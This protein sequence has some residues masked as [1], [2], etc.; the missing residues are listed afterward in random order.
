MNNR[1]L[2]KFNKLHIVSILLFAV[3]ILQSVTFANTKYSFRT[4]GVTTSDD[5][6]EGS[7]SDGETA[8]FKVSDNDNGIISFSV[9]GD[10]SIASKKWGLFTVQVLAKMADGTT[11]EVKYTLYDYN[12]GPGAVVPLASVK[13]NNGGYVINQ[14]T[15]S[16]STKIQV[17]MR[18]NPNN[19][20]YGIFIDSEELESLGLDA[21]F[22][23]SIKLNDT[24]NDQEDN[25]FASNVPSSTISLKE[26]PDD[27]HYAAQYSSIKAGALTEEEKNAFLE[28]FLE[29]EEEEKEDT[30]KGSQFEG[31]IADMILSFGRLIQ[32]IIETSFG[33]DGNNTLS[34]DSLIFNKI[35]QLMIDLRRVF[36]KGVQVGEKINDGAYINDYDVV[37]AIQSIFSGLRFIALVVY[38]MTLLYVGVRTLLNIGTPNESKSKKFLQYWVTGVALLYFVPY[39]LAVIPVISNTMVDIIRDMAK[40]SHTY[41]VQAIAKRLS[42]SYLGED[43]EIPAMREDLNNRIAALKNKASGI[44]DPKTVEEAKKELERQINMVYGLLQLNDPNAATEVKNRLTSLETYVLGN[45]EHWNGSNDREFEDELDSIRIQAYNIRKNAYKN[46]PISV[47]LTGLNRIASGPPIPGPLAGIPNV[48]A[49]RREIDNLEELVRGDDG[50]F[51]YLYGNSAYLRA[52]NHLRQTIESNGYKWNQ[53]GTSVTVESSLIGRFEAY[54]SAYKFY[55]EQ[56][57]PYM[58]AFKDAL[59]V[60]QINDYEEML[61]SLVSDPAQQLHERAKE[62]NRVVYAIAWAIL[63]FQTFA[64]LFMY[65]KRLIVTV[66]LVCLFPVVMAMYVLDKMGDGKSQSLETWFKE[67][68]AN[69]TL[70]FFHAVVYIIV[71]NL[72]I[73]AVRADP[74]RNWFILIIAVC[75]L[76]PVER[77]MRDIL[78]VK[79][80]TVGQLKF[81]GAA[82]IGAGLAVGMTAKNATRLGKSAVGSGINGIKAFKGNLSA[83]HMQ[84]LSGTRAVGSALATGVKNKASKIKEG[85]KDKWKDAK[86]PSA[87]SKRRSDLKEAKRRNR[88]LL[89][90]RAANGGGALTRMRAKASKVAGKVEDAKDKVTGALKNNAIIGTGLK[91][92][93]GAAVIDRF[94]GKTFRGAYMKGVGLAL[95]ATSFVD[96]TS[97]GGLAQGIVNARSTGHGVGGFKNQ[98]KP[99]KKGTPPDNSRSPYSAQYQPISDSTSGFIPEPGGTATG[100]IPRDFGGGGSGD[101]DSETAPVLTPETLATAAVVGGVAGAAASE[102]LDTN[103]GVQE[104]DNDETTNGTPDSTNQSTTGDS[105]DTSTD[106]SA[107]APTE[108]KVEGR[109]VQTEE[110]VE[111]T[112]TAT[113]TIPTAPGTVPNGTDS[114]ELKLNYQEGPEGA[115]LGQVIEQHNESGGPANKA[116][117]DVARPDDTKGDVSDTTKTNF[118]E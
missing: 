76:F 48:D 19:Q 42:S 88:E 84:G 85:L 43:A 4:D 118:N 68:I 103:S 18:L 60:K 27:F 79:S 111:L 95:G 58:K 37:E 24:L 53:E 64:V 17:P 22:S 82:M 55:Y 20:D 78:G 107:D 101:S 94:A 70:Q 38:L 14:S 25:F 71:V 98:K 30:S 62:D 21:T 74:E 36:P 106:T 86:E 96:T 54:V 77:I 72:G 81:N 35:P 9:Q 15:S 41:S 65:V 108:L 99:V 63:M 92:A 23:V 105:R 75:S 67:F 26:K 109:A 49:V 93:H 80:S 13:G 66:I 87:R 100:G 39:F 104:K 52:M 34:L 110:G 83:A 28:D 102:M 97:S 69:T 116:E 91:L 89:Q 114:L 31:I 12:F 47:S 90:E 3:L 51:A 1:F 29:D 112:Q 73:D 61:N 44:V 8:V 10:S 117:G 50:P 56:I 113:G 33:V 7:F 11:R 115:S 57:D 59:V 5:N 45:Y 40:S 46:D 6:N 32:L 2:R 16:S